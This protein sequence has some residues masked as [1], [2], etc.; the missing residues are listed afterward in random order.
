MPGR[1]R[2]RMPGHSSQ[3]PGLLEAP[4]R[5]PKAASAVTQAGARG[6]HLQ[7]EGSYSP[8]LPPLAINPPF[9]CIRESSP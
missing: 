4:P 6:C 8:S 3:Q 7:L 9:L 5:A 2:S 1:H